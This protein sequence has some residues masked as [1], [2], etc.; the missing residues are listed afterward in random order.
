MSSEEH[1][2][3]GASVGE[4]MNGPVA[5]HDV[6]QDAFIPLAERLNVDSLL[7]FISDNCGGRLWHSRDMDR[8]TVL[9]VWK[10]FFIKGRGL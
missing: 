7:D 2:L 3:D 6:S 5:E 8:A 1:Q 4:N 10:A 9:L